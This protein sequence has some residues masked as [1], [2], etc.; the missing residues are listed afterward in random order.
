LPIATFSL[1]VILFLLIIFG[2]IEAR[3]HQNALSKIPTR[4]HVNGTRGKSSVTRLIAAGLRSGG[5]KTYAKTTGSSPRFIDELGND[6]IIQRFRPASIGEQIRMIMRFAKQAPQAIVM[7]CMAIHPQY[8]WV[9][10]HKI[11]NSNYGVITNVRADHLEE[12]G[13]SLNHIARSLSNTIPFNQKFFTSETD[14]VKILEDK[15]KNN[16]ST[17]N[18]SRGKNLNKKYINGFSFIEHPDN[19]ALALDVCK[20]IGVSEDIAIKGMKKMNPDPGALTITKVIINKIKV[21]F[22]NAFAA[23][24]PQS[25]LKTWEI[26]YEFYKDDKKKIALFLNTRSD[27]QLRTQQLLDMIF[28]RMNI[29]YLIVRGD[30]LENDIASRCEDIKKIK[31]SLFQYQDAPSQVINEISKLDNFLIVGIGNIVGWGESFMRE[32]KKYKDA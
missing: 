2:L 12:M 25:T 18:I 14:A 9:S 6:H 20:D 29:D 3:L 21:D 11:L 27:R 4:V 15:T 23:N 5:I 13:Y 24:D 28:S 31:F 19:I 26:I 30:N 10:E 1:L 16:N 32:L 17:F 7:E 8:Q 22:V